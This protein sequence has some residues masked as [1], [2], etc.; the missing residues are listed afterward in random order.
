LDYVQSLDTVLS[1]NPEVV[2]PSH[3]NPIY[4]RDE[5]QRVVSGYRDALLYV[6]D[7]TVRGINA[8]K[9]AYTLMD[10]IRLPPDL[11]QGEAY[12]TVRWTVRGIC[13][14]YVGWFDGNPSNMSSTP[15]SAIYAEVAEL[16]GGPEVIA[17]RASQLVEDGDLYRA[18]HMA[19][20]ALEADPDNRT[21][22][23]AKRAA[24]ASLL[25]TSVNL[26]EQGWL[27]AGMIEIDALLPEQTK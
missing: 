9:S 2:A 6:H 12:G 4:G 17:D 20:F 18:L 19:D 27:H 21:A 14:G 11:E 16:A 23:L 15:A 10:E 22:L 8:G 13:D 26:N 3:G 25:T 24:L 5:V 1:W 7:E